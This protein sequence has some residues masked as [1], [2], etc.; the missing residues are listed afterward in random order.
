M[1]ELSE[2]LA[3]LSPEKRA[4]FEKLLAQQ[5]R[6]ENVFPISVMQ[7]GIWFLEQ[8]KPHTAAYIMPAALRI[9]GRLRPDALR[10]AVNEIVRRHE[11]L[12]T[13]FQLRDGQPVQVV[14][15]QLSVEVP[16]EDLRG[17]GDVAARIDEV[18]SEPFDLGSAPLLRLRLLRTAEDEHVLAVAMH[19]LISDGWSTGI[20]IS[21]L[22]A[23]YKA[24][25]EGRPS[26]L[27]ELT[28]QYGDFATWQREW[29]A[30]DGL[31][32]HLAYWRQHLAGAPAALA[33]PTDR[34]RPAVQGFNGGT[35]PFGLSE[36]LMRELGAL[37]KRYRATTFMALLA[38][39]QVVLHRYSNQDNVVVGVPTVTR[40]RP[41]IEPVIGYFVNLLPV[42]TD[43]S[44]NPGFG[45]VL[46][47]VRDGCLGAYG[48]QAVPFEKIV[49]DVKPPRDLSRPPIFQACF[50]YQSDPMPTFTVAG[51]EFTRLPLKA[52]GAR[53]DLELQSFHDGGGLSG[54]FEYDRDLFDGASI[55][56]LA[57]HFRR[58]VE[59]V[60]ARPEAPVDELPLLDE[61]ERRRLV[62]EA[63]A[64]DRQ[65]PGAGWI[66]EC[67]EERARCAP[68]APALRFEGVQLSYGEVNR[69]ANRLARL[70]AGLGV[71]RDVLV[72]VAME[73][74][75][76]LV[77]GL[78]A[79]LKAG[80]AYVPLDPGYP[81]ARLEYMLAD[82]GVAVLLTQRRLVAGLP[83]CA[84]R[85]LCVDELG[86]ELATQPDGNLDVPVDGTDL[87][88][89][90][91]TSGSTGQPKGALNVHRAIRNRLLWMQDEYR[92]DGTDRVL[93]KT[94][95]SFDVSVW[96][97]FWPLMVGASLVVAR[98]HAHKDGRYLVATIRDEHITTLHFVPSMLQ[99]FLREPGVE[100]LTGL[101]RV[102]C[103]GEALPRDLQERF[104]TRCPAEL[105]N[106][107]GP[108][109]AAVDVTSWAC[110]RDGDPRPVPIG[111][112]IAN[113]QMYV[114]DRFLQPVPVGVAGE[115][116]I[117]GV[118]LARGYLNK[119]ELTTTRFIPD[120]FH[121]H[122][123]SGARL[124]KTGDL[125]RVREDGA[126]EYLGRLDRQ[127]KLRG[128]RIELGE[129]E[130]VLTDHDQVSE[131]IVVAREH[132]TGDVRLVAYLTGTQV[133]SPGELI[134]YIKDRLPEYMVPAAFVTLRAFPLLP[135]GKVDQAALPEPDLGR[136]ELLNPYVAPRDDLER[137][138]AAVW[139]QV[140]GLDRVGSHDNFFELGGH[141]L[142]IP[143]LKAALDEATGREVAM[144][145]LFQ[146]PT[147]ASLAEYLNRPASGG[148]PLL[149]AQQRAQSRREARDQRQQASD[150]RQRA[151]R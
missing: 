117:G 121:P 34:P 47:R 133:P 119:P 44:G 37:A 56:R 128:F 132:A 146:Y 115:L 40:E 74:S 54:T 108:T 51:V 111:Y 130:S 29:V 27:P 84:A 41:E 91:Y 7:Q 118:N 53:F 110:R 92:L 101:R 30:K 104:F 98:P 73:R 86:D 9:R 55:E 64:T 105:H 131:A 107:Y 100:E 122:P 136:P 23:L 106:L 81:R 82:S 45:E 138:I 134:A 15:G 60:V 97:F 43:L 19:H 21:E 28:L 5:G 1:T 125:A 3:A 78:L 4:L 31:A 94:P 10:A 150:R 13:A 61:G 127:V 79:I 39:F 63:N 42:H 33:L 99:A 87:A 139:C 89:M 124:Y 88:Y 72:G 69:R 135:N 103:S 50:S 142:L 144:V 137:S 141:S 14:S 116:H 59:L 35:V 12:R 16:E 38:I 148:S 52:E 46:E 147:V 26:P 90:I 129:I 75:V 83:P 20:L 145:E 25:V 36:A 123:D 140:L 96:E 71:R 93:Q 68:D 24:F 22:A 32:P 109:E 102:I 65:W 114:L 17:G 149:D 58:L 18:V 151:R 143:Q 2:R 8:L 112:P 80:G 95:F 62:V 49:E 11:A 120:P 126:I 85:V 113:T 48:H 77:V 70:L 76:E 67:F 66:H 57:G 6:M